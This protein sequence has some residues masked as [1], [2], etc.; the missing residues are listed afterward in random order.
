MRAESSAS[1]RKSS[2]PLADL[3]IGGFDAP[4]VAIPGAMIQR[5]AL[6]YASTAALRA[7]GNRQGCGLRGIPGRKLLFL[8]LQHGIDRRTAQRFHQRARSR[9]GDVIV[10]PG[11]VV[12]GILPD[13]RGAPLQA[14]ELR[15]QPLIFQ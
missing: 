7:H 14:R 9:I 8:P 13:P 3:R 15:D 10:G 6:G 2:S 5:S 1:S 12:N 4:L 11:R